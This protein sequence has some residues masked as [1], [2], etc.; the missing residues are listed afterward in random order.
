MAWSYTDD[1]CGTG[2]WLTILIRLVTYSSCL[3]WL[4]L[5]LLISGVTTKRLLMIHLRFPTYFAWCFDPS[6]SLSISLLSSNSSPPIILIPSFSYHILYIGLSSINSSHF[7][8]SISFLPHNNKQI[9]GS[10]WK[11]VSVSALQGSV[12]Q[13]HALTVLTEAVAYLSAINGVIV[14]TGTSHW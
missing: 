12:I 2:M 9:T 10:T 5:I 4:L 13:F 14:K 6:P 8:L 7:L 1:V 11:S 3:C